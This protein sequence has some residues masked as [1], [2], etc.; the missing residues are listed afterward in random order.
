MHTEKFAKE[1][2]GEPVERQF[3]LLILGDV[4]GPNFIAVKGYLE[5]LRGSSTLYTQR[6]GSSRWQF[7]ISEAP[8][9]LSSS[10]GLQGWSG[11]SGQ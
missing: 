2:V 1:D 8:G 4:S 10:T 3:S 11:R 9:I 5:N 6:P 7:L